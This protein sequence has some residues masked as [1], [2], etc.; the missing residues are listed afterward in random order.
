MDNTVYFNTLSP[1]NVENEKGFDDEH[2]VTEC[3][4]LI[5]FRKT[6]EVRVR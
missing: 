5:I 2:S 3:P 6:T 4:E 1:Y